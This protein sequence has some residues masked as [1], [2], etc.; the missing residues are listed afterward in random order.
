MLIFL[1]VMAFYAG[2]IQRA[3]LPIIMRCPIAVMPASL[4]QLLLMPRRLIGHGQSC[5]AAFD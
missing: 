4:S 3:V 1:P 5:D 2:S